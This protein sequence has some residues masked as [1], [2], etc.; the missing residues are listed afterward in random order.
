MTT[1]KQE[2]RGVMTFNDD[3]DNGCIA[4]VN[5]DYVVVDGEIVIIFVNI[6]PGRHMMTEAELISES[7]RFI[8]E[9]YTQRVSFETKGNVTVQN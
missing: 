9:Q 7:Y 4:V 6:N 5:W 1:T 3:L 2:E 8:R